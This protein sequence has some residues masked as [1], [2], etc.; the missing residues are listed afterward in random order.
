MYG[1][2]EPK[3]MFQYADLNATGEVYS[4][5]RSVSNQIDEGVVRLHS[6]EKK[7][8]MLSLGDTMKARLSMQK[9]N[10]N[11]RNQVYTS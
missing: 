7:K 1:P 6:Q 5:L 11:N 8:Y 3:V 2:D 10:S 9:R 4:Q